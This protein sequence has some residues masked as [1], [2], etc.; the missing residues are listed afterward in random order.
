MLGL[1][2]GVSYFVI[3]IAKTEV[4]EKKLLTEGDPSLVDAYYKQ[5]L[6]LHP[7]KQ[8]LWGNYLAFLSWRGDNDRFKAVA[9]RM[10]LNFDD[11]R[12]NF[13]SGLMAM[14]KGDTEQAV[15]A[16]QKA[17][18]LNPRDPKTTHYLGQLYY[19]L[20]QYDKA[21]WAFVN[22]VNL[23]TKNFNDDYIYLCDIELRRGNYKQ[24]RKYMEQAPD[25]WRKDHYDN[26]LRGF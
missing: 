13:Y 12:L 19:S 6:G 5:A 26:L 14:R 20:G 17:H 7:Y 2:F 22:T 10:A 25:S 23:D 1:S 18:K 3:R 4:L 24:A 15:V 21:E 16:L 11:Y 8:S 9:D